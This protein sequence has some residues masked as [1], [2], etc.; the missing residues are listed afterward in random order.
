MIKFT[1]I[2]IVVYQVLLFFTRC[3]IRCLSTLD[4]LRFSMKKYTKKEHIWLL[5]LLLL[6]LACIISG[7]ISVIMLAIRFL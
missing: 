1:V 3:Y 2:L 4:Q 5:I 6:K 7:A